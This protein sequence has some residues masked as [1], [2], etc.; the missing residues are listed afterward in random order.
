[1]AMPNFCRFCFLI[2]KKCLFFLPLVTSFWLFNFTTHYSESD[3]FIHSFVRSMVL[4]CVLKCC[5]FC[6][7]YRD[8]QTKTIC[9]FLNKQ[10]KVIMLLAPDTCGEQAKSQTQTQIQTSLMLRK[11]SLWYPPIYLF[12][13]L[14]ASL[15][16]YWTFQWGTAS[17]ILSNNYSSNNP[18]L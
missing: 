14:Y 18:H 12:I 6:S 10:I 16:S 1:M 13:Y 8:M 7:L 5:F 15:E 17:S 9:L 3:S 2:H 4:C 11:T